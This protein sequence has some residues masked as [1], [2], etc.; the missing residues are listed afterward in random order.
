[1]VFANVV[2][3]CTLLKLFQ[4]NID[5]VLLQ[6]SQMSKLQAIGVK[7]VKKDGVSPMV[8]LCSFLRFLKILQNFCNSFLLD[9]HYFDKLSLMQIQKNTNLVPANYFKKQENIFDYT[10]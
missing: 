9:A 6:I 2:A 1:M 8:L 10:I 5:L 3:K 4:I 7:Q